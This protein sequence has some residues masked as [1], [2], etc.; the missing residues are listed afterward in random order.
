MAPVHLEQE[1]NVLRTRQARLEAQL[2]RLPAEIAERE[3]ELAELNAEFL[4]YT[5]T[6][7]S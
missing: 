6:G 5:I 2:A 4:P 3:Q 7:T 1:L